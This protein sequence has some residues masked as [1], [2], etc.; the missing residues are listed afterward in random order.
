MTAVSGGEGITRKNSTS[1]LIH[2]QIGPFKLH[3]PKA[4]FDLDVSLGPVLPSFLNPRA[5]LPPQGAN[6][7]QRFFLK[8]SVSGPTPSFLISPQSSGSC[9]C[10]DG[11]L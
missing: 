7:L 9:S 6:H 2:R 4:G 5:W 3:M 1:S 8:S 10:I 11:I